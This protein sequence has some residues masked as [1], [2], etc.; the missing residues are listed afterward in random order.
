MVRANVCKMD[1]NFKQ[2]LESPHES[3][4][5]YAMTLSQCALCIHS[6]KTDCFIPKE[7]VVVPTSTWGKLLE[8]FKEHCIRGSG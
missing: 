1:C 3:M 8:A 7:E 5:F 2:I 6:E 4:E